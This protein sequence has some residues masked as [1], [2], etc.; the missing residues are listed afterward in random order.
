MANC[1]CVQNI[2]TGREKLLPIG[3]VIIFGVKKFHNYLFGTIESDHK[4]LYYM[5]NKLRGISPTAI[6]RWALTLRYDTLKSGNMLSNA[7]ALRPVTISGVRVPGDLV[8]LIHRSSVNYDRQS[9]QC[10]RVDY[11]RAV[12]VASSEIHPPWLAGD[13][14]W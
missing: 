6:Q 1:L 7:D 5:F 9:R 13:S 11:K 12:V 4:L 2:N 3:V 10:N 8:Q 14:T